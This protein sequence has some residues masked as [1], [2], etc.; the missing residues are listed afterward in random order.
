MKPSLRSR[1]EPRR[2]SNSVI[3]GAMLLSLCVLS[4]VKARY[5]ATPFGTPSILCVLLDPLAWWGSGSLC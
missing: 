3:I 5:C 2:V 4:I 1:Q